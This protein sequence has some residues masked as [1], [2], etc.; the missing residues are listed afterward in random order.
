MDLNEIIS[1]HTLK[2]SH[3]LTKI[4]EPLKLI[5][6]IKGFFHYTISPKGLFT[7]IGTHPT[8][9]EEYY[10][11]KYYL[12][13]PFL[14]HPSTLHEGVHFPNTAR[15]EQYLEMLQLRR[16]RIDA[17]H[18]MILVNKVHGE[19]DAF[20]FFTNTDNPQIYNF[21]M[22]EMS[23]LRSFIDFF[24]SEMKEDLTHLKMSPANMALAK[25]ELFFPKE[26]KKIITTSLRHAFLKS[27]GKDL[28]WLTSIKLTNREKEV[29]KH[30]RIGKTAQEIANLLFISRRTVEKFLENIKLKLHCERR[31]EIFDRLIELEQLEI[32]NLS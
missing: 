16:K 27:I 12:H 1:E 31:S 32:L 7:I 4:L 19:I 23:L 13:N 22:N 20:C 15:D 29:L 21:Y 28:N 9:M 6:G 8:W 25:K 14:C 3:K 24:K 11:E 10:N 2:K 17:D 30:L 5:S 18:A 26:P